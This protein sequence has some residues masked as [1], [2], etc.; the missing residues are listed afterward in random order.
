MRLKYGWVLMALGLAACS[1]EPLDGEALAATK[2]CIAC[3]GT[4]GVAQI[5]G[6][7]NLSGQWEEYLR[8]QLMAY[9]SGSRTNALMNGMAEGLTDPEIRA[10]AAHYGK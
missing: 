7:P 4:S 10:L 9:R 3:H 2:G 8:L 5:D 6:Y 1:E